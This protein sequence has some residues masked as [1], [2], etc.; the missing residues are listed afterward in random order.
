ML[1]VVPRPVTGCNQPTPRYTS[2]FYIPNLTN[3]CTNILVETYLSRPQPWAPLSSHKV[4]QRVMI[5]GA[6]APR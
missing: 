4:T 3:G 5:R 2:L 1:P 6:F